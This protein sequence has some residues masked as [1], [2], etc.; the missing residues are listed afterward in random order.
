MSAVTPAAVALSALCLIE[1]ERQ[2]LFTGT[3][4]AAHYQRSAQPHGGWQGLL[5]SE[6]ITDF[7]NRSD[8]G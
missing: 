4:R 8:R 5:A 1:R 2:E 7:A 3:G 6:N